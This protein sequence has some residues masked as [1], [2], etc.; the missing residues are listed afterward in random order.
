MDPFTMKEIA[1]AASEAQGSEIPDFKNWESQKNPAEMSKLPDFDDLGDRIPDFSES[2]K[3]EFPDR[4]IENDTS[5]RRVCETSPEDSTRTIPAESED[6]NVSQENVESSETN[7]YP[8]T[9]EERLKQTPVDGERGH[10]EGERGESK[11]VPSDPRIQEILDKYGMDGVEY[12]DGIPD[13]SD[14]SEATVEIDNMSD[15]RQ[16]PGGNFEQADQKCADKWNEEARDG[17][18]DWTARDVADWRHAN[19]YS[20]HECNDMK[21]CQLVPTEVN[22]YFGHLGGVGECNRANRTQE[23]SFDE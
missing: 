7:E 4:D 16:G 23:V 17:R 14:C 22:D 5:G 12:N 2:T 9:Y 10:W 13:F 20:W 18:T 11:Y 19:H 8:S 6:Y 15:K 3:S 21:T 1:A